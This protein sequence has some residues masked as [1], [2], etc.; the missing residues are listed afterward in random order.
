MGILSTITGLVSSNPV[1]GTLKMQILAVVGGGVLVACLGLGFYIHR[2]NVNIATL[3]T[4]KIQL[5]ANNQ[6]LIENNKVL[7]KNVNKIIEANSTTSNTVASLIS[8]RQDATKA[9]SNLAAASLNDKQTIAKLK[10]NLADIIK[11][12]N[13]DGLVAPALRET[14]RSIQ[15]GGK[16]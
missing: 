10:S 8:E 11:D 1:T 5:T 9:I 7:K 4:E 6:I 2:L 12:P 14:V 13:N 15:E 3:Q 16:K